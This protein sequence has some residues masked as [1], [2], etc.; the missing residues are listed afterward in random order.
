MGPVKVVS[1]LFLSHRKRLVWLGRCHGLPLQQSEE[2]VQDVFIRF[3]HEINLGVAID[4]KVAWLFT[5]C[6]NRFR[7]VIKSSDQKN[8]VYDEERL[9]AEEDGE[10][11]S[12]SVLIQECVNRKLEEFSFKFPSAALAIRAQLDGMTSEEIG[13]MIGRSA[14]ATRQFLHLAKKKLSY[15]LQECRELLRD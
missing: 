3:Y 8:L 10:L 12:N 2:V 1:D 14:V 9:L 11:V 4:N 5:A 6:L 13:T 7:D 15:F